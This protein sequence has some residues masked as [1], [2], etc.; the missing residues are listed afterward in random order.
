MLETA[1]VAILSA[2]RDR[3]P[4]S[5]LQEWAQSQGHGTPYYR[6]INSH[7]PDHAKIFEVEVYV[8]NQI[9]GRGVG[10]SK[11]SAAK[12]AAEAALS[13]LGLEY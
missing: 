6:T 3:D 11:Q 12:A 9:L 7:G 1:A 4:K 5:S 2:N 10:Q 13:S 8:G